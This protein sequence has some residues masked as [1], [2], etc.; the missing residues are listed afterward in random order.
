MNYEAIAVWSQVVSAVL[1]LV[2]LVWGWFK[3]IQP[4]VLAAQDRQNARLAEAERHRD[5]AKAALDVLRAEIDGATRDAGLIR[6]R[7][8]EQGASEREAI[9]ASAREA[10]ERSL[11][12]AQGELARAREAARDQLRVEM[13]ERAL[14]SAR[15]KAAARV[16][17]S[18]NA[19]LVGKFVS[20]LEAEGGK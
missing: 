17:A 11:R 3:Y 4:A 13:L 5:E 12:G 8:V 14:Q 7:A 1:F 2:V 20:S 16:D 15:E 18:M 19:A 6:R 10:G 9:V